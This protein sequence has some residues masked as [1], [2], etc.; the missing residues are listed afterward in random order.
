[1]EDAGFDASSV[2]TIEVQ[3]LGTE[4]S[5]TSSGGIDNLTF[6]PEPGTGLLLGSGLLLLA[7]RRHP[8]R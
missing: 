2:D 6:I 1:M 8:R 7:L 5:G 3:L 4:P